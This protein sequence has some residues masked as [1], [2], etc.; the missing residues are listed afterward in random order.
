M[1]TYDDT[2]KEVGLNASHRD[3]VNLAAAI[4][5]LADAIRDAFAQRPAATLGGGGSGGESPAGPTKT[6]PGPAVTKPAPAAE[7]APAG[8]AAPAPTPDAPKVPSDEELRAALVTAAR[9]C[10]G[11]R[12][13]IAKMKELYKI[14]KVTDCPPEQRDS[15]L[16]TL[17]GIARNPPTPDEIPF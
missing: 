13:P 16:A 3:S 11:G 9:A 8:T 2:L 7:T 12:V 4:V 10:G 5:Y 14:D 15:L 1:K 6:K 17:D